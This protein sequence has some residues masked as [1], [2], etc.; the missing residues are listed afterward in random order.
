[1]QPVLSSAK[2]LEKNKEKQVGELQATT[3]T[4]GHSKEATNQ[5]RVIDEIEAARENEDQS[6]SYTNSNRFEG[7]I[8]NI[9]AVT[10]AKPPRQLPIK[11]RFLQK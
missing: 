5:M 4:S 1:M 3:M 11:S 8:V 10:G 9:K 7:P 6:E 2:L